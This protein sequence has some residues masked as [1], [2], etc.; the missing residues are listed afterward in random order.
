MKTVGTRIILFAG[1]F[2][3]Y[4]KLNNEAHLVTTSFVIAA[5]GIG[6]MVFGP[7]K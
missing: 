2:F 6:L 4:A 3:I 7:K 5:I 1:A